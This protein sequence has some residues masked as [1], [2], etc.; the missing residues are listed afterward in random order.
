MKVAVFSTES[1]DRKFLA[2]ANVDSDCFLMDLKLED[3]TQASLMVASPSSVSFSM[4]L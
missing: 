3:P 2:A 4:V 1:Y